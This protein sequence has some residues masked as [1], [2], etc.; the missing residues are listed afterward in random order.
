MKKIVLLHTVKSVIDIF[1]KLITESIPEAQLYNIYDDY[2]VLGLKDGGFIPYNKRR[3]F[4]YLELA[5][6]I[7]P[8]VIL[9][10]C[11]SL[12]TEIDNY[13]SM[14]DIPIIRVDENMVK[15]AIQMG[16]RI[17][18]MAT[19]KSVVQPMVKQLEEYATLNE[20]KVH[21]EVFLTEEA[22]FALRR[23]DLELHDK[24]LADEAY[25]IGKCDVVVLAQASMMRSSKQI[26]EICGVPVLTSPATAVELL[27]KNLNCIE[28]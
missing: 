1:D 9:V 19:A 22:I 17:A 14:F 10:T 27:L 3:L 20:K 18:V 25:K 16:E 8:D 6:E 2:L 11:S 4:K 15:K 28:Q 26:E 24:L 13:R 23:G 21:I 12:S 7:Q 5:Q